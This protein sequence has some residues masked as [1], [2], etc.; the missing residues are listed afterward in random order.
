MAEC[1]NQGDSPSSSG[2]ER[3]QSSP[4]LSDVRQ[5][6]RTCQN[7][8]FPVPIS[9]AKWPVLSRHAR[10]RTPGFGNASI[11]SCTHML[12]GYRHGQS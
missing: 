8:K 10:R 11:S 3:N 2:E 9:T 6:N 5:Q 4:V 1:V 7:V 12:V